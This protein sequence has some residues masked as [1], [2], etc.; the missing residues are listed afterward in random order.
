[1]KPPRK[2][3]VAF[4]IAFTILLLDGV[5]A[6]WLGQV[7]GR[8]ALLIAGLVL[9]TA[10][11]G[12]GVLYQRWRRALEEIE[13]ARRDLQQEIGALRRAVEDARAGGSRGA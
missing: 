1:V 8:R 11:L 6:V 7:T 2:W 10:A 3:T 4:G 13:A 9:M 5:A 12:V